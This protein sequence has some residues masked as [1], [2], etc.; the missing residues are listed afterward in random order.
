MSGPLA[1][2]EQMVK[3]HVKRW[4]SDINASVKDVQDYMRGLTRE[5]KF[6]VDEFDSAFATQ[7]ELKPTSREP[8]VY[9]TIV[10][11]V[12]GGLGISTLLIG[13]RRLTINNNVNQIT[14][15][16]CEMRVYENDRRILLSGTPEAPD[17]A[18]QMFFEMTGRM[19][20]HQS[21]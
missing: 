1:A 18:V 8:V 10:V 7:I 17:A 15:I 6:M 19:F 5:S 11:S 3:E 14:T 2:E 9:N 13:R 20:P 12:N 21:A 16:K 4:L